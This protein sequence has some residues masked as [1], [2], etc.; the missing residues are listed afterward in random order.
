MNK[1]ICAVLAVILICSTAFAGCGSE[2]ADAKDLKV[3][4]FSGGDDYITVSNGVIVLSDGYNALYFGDLKADEEHFSDITSLTK[5]FYVYKDGEKQTLSQNSVTDTTGGT[6]KVGGEMGKMW[7]EAGILGRTVPEDVENNL[8]FQL[9]TTD[10]EGNVQ[11]Y[12]LQMKVVEVT[13]DTK[14]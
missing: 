11:N 1:K 7:G 2:K 5:T 4:S 13:E 12:Q 8:F 14:A 9:E 3:Y 6:I 10:K